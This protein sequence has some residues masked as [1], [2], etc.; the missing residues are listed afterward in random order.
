[1]IQ[2]LTIIDAEGRP[3]EKGALH[4]R[5]LNADGSVATSQKAEVYSGVC[6]VE[7]PDEIL[8]KVASRSLEKVASRE[9]IA[10]EKAASVDEAIAAE[11]DA[12]KDVADVATEVGV[13]NDV[14]DTTT[15]TAATTASSTRT[16]L[17]I[18]DMVASSG[19]QLDAARSAISTSGVA[20]GDVRLTV[21]GVLASTDTGEV[22]LKMPIATDTVGSLSELT[23]NYSTVTPK[24]TPAPTPVVSDTA[25]KV[26]DLT[27]YTHQMALRKLAAQGLTALVNTLTVAQGSPENGRVVRQSPPAGSPLPTSGQIR[28]FL[29]KEQVTLG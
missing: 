13:G 6:K 8:G 7:L 22:A 15:A 5:V 28:L 26:P 23:A 19:Q 20:L 27:G 10:M 24:P 1:M 12:V 4:I 3:L 11:V 9:A 16:T 2:V 17:G 14:A 29:G 18:G 25:V 21:R